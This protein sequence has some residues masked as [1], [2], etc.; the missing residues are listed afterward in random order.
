MK[1]AVL[2]SSGG[3]GSYF[4]DY[5]ARLGHNVAGSD[6]RPGRS[7]T[8]IRFV[9]T[10]LEAVEGADVVLLAVPMSETL[11]V[12]RGVAQ[13]LKS[14][15]TLVEIT[16]VK[17]SRLSVLRKL[18]TA[19]GVSLLSVHPMF[20]PSSRSKAPKILVVGTRK[21]LAA[22]GRVFP[23]SKLILVGSHEHDRL[24]AH[25]LS[26]V[27]LTNIA[28]VSAVEKGSGV[29]EYDRVA[30]PFASAQLELAKAV[31]S[32][33]P[34]LYSQIDTEN[35][36]AT[37]ALSALIAELSSLKDLIERKDAET[38]N[39]EF[40]RVARWFTVSETQASLARVYSAADG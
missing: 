9:R 18:A 7:H 21:D 11:N 6:L 8:R 28:F 40:K 13:A 22:A 36:S 38:L 34:T 30:P 15:C 31:L 33:D 4:A 1:V 25:T 3:M 26:L 20:G 27:H 29:A 14:G 16:S 2:G 39:E 32:Q 5:F 19:H 12:A 23:G 37:A 10:N 24:M 17:G 35:R